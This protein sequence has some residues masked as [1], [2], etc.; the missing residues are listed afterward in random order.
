MTLRGYS[1]DVLELTPRMRAVLQS[2]AAGRTELETALE[3][4][5]SVST[6]KTIRAAAIARL[7]ASNV[8]AAVA[9]AVR[10]GEL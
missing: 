4:H 8:V 2:A 1:P 5:V 9:I 7:G 10:N 3:L 6:V